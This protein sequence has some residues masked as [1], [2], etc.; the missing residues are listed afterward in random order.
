MNEYL[1]EGIWHRVHFEY[2]IKRKAIGETLR[3]KVLALL[4]EDKE[5]VAYAKVLPDEVAKWER[6]LCLRSIY[7]GYLMCIGL[8]GVFVMVILLSLMLSRNMGDDT[9]VIQDTPLNW[10]LISLPIFFCVVPVFAV[11][12]VCACVDMNCYAPR[13]GKVYARLNNGLLPW[14]LN[15]QRRYNVDARNIVRSRH[16][17][18]GM[19]VVPVTLVCM[20]IHGLSGNIIAY[21]YCYIPLYALLALLCLSPLITFKAMFLDCFDREN[22][23]CLQVMSRSWKSCMLMTMI[24][25]C[26]S[27]TAFLYSLHLDGVIWRGIAS[28]YQYLVFLLPLFAL[29]FFMCCHF[30]FHLT[31]LCVTCV[32]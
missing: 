1:W 26:I 27:L 24:V 21:S 3:E 15:L 17:V 11:M 31:G 32:Y 5:L 10:V 29:F 30:P 22:G 8:C 7:G 2:A 28:W 18:L 23:Q 4:M 19:L 14:K 12:F 20:V 9:V 6:P 25:L 13:L 16:C